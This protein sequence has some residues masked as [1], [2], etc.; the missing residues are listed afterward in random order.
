ML[1]MKMINIEAC[2]QLTNLTNLI[3][4]NLTCHFKFFFF[5]GWV[6][7]FNC[8]KRR[9]KELDYIQVRKFFNTKNLTQSM[10]LII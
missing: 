6:N 8:K 2:I 3:Q 9:K 5:W 1:K 4:S 10:Q 7:R